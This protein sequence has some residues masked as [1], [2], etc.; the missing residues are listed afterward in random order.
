MPTGVGIDAFREFRIRGGV[1]AE[2]S[3][4]AAYPGNGRKATPEARSRLR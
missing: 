1:E 2:S 3:A 4:V